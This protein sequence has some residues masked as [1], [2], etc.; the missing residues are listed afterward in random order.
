MAEL[1]DL[2]GYW[3]STQFNGDM[4]N[5]PGLNWPVSPVLF[6][7]FEPL[8]PLI[9]TTEMLDIFTGCADYV[10]PRQADTYVA[11]PEFEELVIRR[12]A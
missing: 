4:L 7:T 5:G 11:P 10:V 8:Q 9:V 6:D 12:S 3:N 2:Y 1:P